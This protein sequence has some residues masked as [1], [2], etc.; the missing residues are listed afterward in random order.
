[1]LAVSSLPDGRDQTQ[2]SLTPICTLGLMSGAVELMSG[3]ASNPLRDVHTALE[4]HAR[5]VGGP[6][7]A[8]VAAAVAP[9]ADM[10]ACGCVRATRLSCPSFLC[11]H[12][13]AS[14]AS[15]AASPGV[16]CSVAL[17][18]EDPDGAFSFGAYSAAGSRAGSQSNVQV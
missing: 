8:M 3:P 14:L 11:A 6:A 16:S 4:K 17:L 1:M 9:G 5:S 12:Y 7:T 2:G 13:D 15:H 18:R 10:C